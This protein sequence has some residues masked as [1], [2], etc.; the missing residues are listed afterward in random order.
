MSDIKV[1]SEQ[2]RCNELSVAFL[3]TWNDCHLSVMIENT[4]QVQL[5][6]VVSRH[7]GWDIGNG[8]RSILI[9]SNDANKKYY[10]EVLLDPKKFYVQKAKSQKSVESFGNFAMFFITSTIFMLLFH[11][12]GKNVWFKFS[13]VSVHKKVPGN[14]I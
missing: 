8:Q 12:K 10:F 2:N 3:S 13:T 5:N 1:T 6:L 4:S 14:L 7:R 11:K 9:T